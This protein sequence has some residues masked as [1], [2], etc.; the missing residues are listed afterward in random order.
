MALVSVSAPVMP[1]RNLTDRVLALLERVDYRRVE[2]TEEREAIFGL[3]YNSY[4]H[5]GAI[6]PNASERFADPLD[7]ASNAWIFGRCS[8]SIA[9]LPSSLSAY[10]IDASGLRS[11]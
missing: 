9:G 5:E 1:G 10:W 3:R 2:T 6:P 4:L 8:A 11:S 7:D